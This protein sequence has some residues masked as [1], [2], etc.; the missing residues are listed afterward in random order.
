MILHTDTDRGGRF[1]IPMISE[2][3]AHRLINLHVP[4]VIPLAVC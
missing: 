3:A 1:L 2:I 4:V